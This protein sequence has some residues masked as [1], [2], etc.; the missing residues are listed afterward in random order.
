MM[1]SAKLTALFLRRE[2]GA[3]L[4]TTIF[5]LFCLCGLLSMLL[6]V[7]QAGLHR[8]KVQQTADIVTKGARAAGKWEYVDGNGEIQK[9]LIAT[10]R[11]AERRNASII[12]GAREEADILIT[13][14]EPALR[15]VLE[16]VTVT[17]QKGEQRYLYKQ[18]IYHLRLEAKSNIQLFWEVMLLSFSRVS[19]SGLR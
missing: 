6:L 19:Q 5:F 1:R 18:G 8:T 10:T 7:E 15:E 11:E 12:R 4:L 2:E 17:H 3:I 16:Q 14:N 9:I 13:L